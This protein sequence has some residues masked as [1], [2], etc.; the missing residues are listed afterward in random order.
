[1][2]ELSPDIL[3]IR[4]SVKTSAGNIGNIAVSMAD[5]DIP[6]ILLPVNLDLIMMDTDLVA[7]LRTRGTNAILA[8]LEAHT[9]ELLKIFAVPRILDGKQA[10]IFGR[11][12][13]S[14]S[15]PAGNLNGDYVYKKTG[16][17]IQYRSNQLAVK[18]KDIDRLLQS[19]A[20]CHHVMIAGTYEKAIR[21]EMMRMG[22]GILGP[23][24]MSSPV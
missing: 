2:R 23:S 12:F 19:L 7:A 11:P 6:V 4:P 18:L 8:N 21:E 16:L 3:I 14:T 13:D 17:R 24:D 1:M 10:L 15:V 20:G 22:V 9:V 5:L